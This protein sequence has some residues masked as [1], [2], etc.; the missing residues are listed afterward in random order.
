MKCSIYMHWPF[1]IRKCNYCDLNSHVDPEHDG[2]QYVDGMLAELRRY[3]ILYPNLEINTIFLGGGTPSLMK[4][5]WIEQLINKIY[6]LWRVS[7]DVEITME[8]NPSSSADL[9][10]FRSAGINRISFGVQAFQDHILKFLGRDHTAQ[11]AIKAI[12]KGMS[13]FPRSSIDI[14]YGVPGQTMSDMQENLNYIK[15]LGLQHVSMYALTIEPNTLFGRIN[16]ALPPENDFCD[17][18]DLLVSEMPKL[19]LMQYEISNFAAYGEESRHNLNYWQYGNWLPIGPGACGRISAQGKRFSIENIKQPRKWLSNSINQ[20]EIVEIS[21]QDALEEEF[22][23][24]LRILDG[25]TKNDIRRMQISDL[26]IENMIATESIVNT[27]SGIC[28]TSE[29]WLKYNSVIR[30][31]WSGT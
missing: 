27:A 18:Y 15:K 1:C 17:M 26:R 12:E 8:A 7:S 2:P 29:G 16:L 22:I 3:G 14:I 4:A 30:Y 31:L 11:D 28:L 13:I 20:T 23:M 25:L 6:K 5:E 21:L 24:K 10:G 9:E 19:G